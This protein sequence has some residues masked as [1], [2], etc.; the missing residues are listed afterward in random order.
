M[1]ARVAEQIQGGLLGD[2]LG[3]LTS[4][5]PIKKTVTEQFEVFFPLF[6]AD[7]SFPT[8]IFQPT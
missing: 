1:A 5:T 3:K 7:C 4:Y 2:Q 8:T 6:G